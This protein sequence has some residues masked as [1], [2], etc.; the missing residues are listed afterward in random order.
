MGEASRRGTFEQRKAK[1]KIRKPK[2]RLSSIMQIGRTA[3]DIEAEH[4]EKRAA[5]KERNKIKIEK[6]VE[7]NKEKRKKTLMNK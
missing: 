3:K 5:R 2:R 4:V 1:S 6:T 7:R